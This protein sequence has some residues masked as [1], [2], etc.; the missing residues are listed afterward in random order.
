MLVGWRR[1]PRALRLLAAML[2]TAVWAATGVAMAL[3]DDAVARTAGDAADALRYAAWFLFVGKLL[4][5]R[6][7]ADSPA[8]ALESRR[9]TLALIAVAL[10]AGVLLSDSLPIAKALGVS[11]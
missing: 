11:N 6:P 7:D 1:N 9:S 3:T 4:E 5:G 10:V 8:P 2:A